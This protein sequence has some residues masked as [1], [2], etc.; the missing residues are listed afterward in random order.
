[1][2]AAIQDAG[3][4]ELSDWLPSSS[5]APLY[6]VATVD[7]DQELEPLISSTS[8]SSTS[9]DTTPRAVRHSAVSQSA[10]AN[11]S[12]A[13]SGYLIQRKTHQSN[14]KPRSFDFIMP[15]LK[16]SKLAYYANKLAVESEPGLTTT[17]L[18]LTNL[19]LKPVEPERR[20]WG[21]WNFVAFWIGMNSNL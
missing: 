19:D 21:A 2:S 11:P 20:Q 7:A 18:M 12:L 14:G 15:K 10:G 9:W 3:D 4:I 6:A 1:M 17:Q 16:N 13:E 8:P 5:R